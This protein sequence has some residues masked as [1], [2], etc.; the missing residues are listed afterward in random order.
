MGKQAV[1]PIETHC[2]A[3]YTG[4]GIPLM[5]C[6]N[7]EIGWPAV[8]SRPGQVTALKE[9]IAGAIIADDENNVALNSAGLFR[10][11]PQLDAAQPIFGNL[12]FYRGLPIAFAQVV[13]TDGRVRL[14]DSF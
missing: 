8:V 5:V 13:F 7:R 12:K 3:G 10:Q 6:I 2:S 11:F 9:Q 1:G 14:R 4:A